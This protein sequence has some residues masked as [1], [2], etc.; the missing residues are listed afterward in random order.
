MSKEYNWRD[1][2]SFIKTVDYPL[3][4]YKKLIKK[5]EKNI[6]IPFENEEKQDILGRAYKIFLS[7]AGKVDNKN[8]VLTSDHIK[9]LMVRLAR[10]T[11]QDVVLDEVVA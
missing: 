5:I 1:K 3:L 6:F 11:L 7:K 4:K 9:A 2:F 8:I 10:L